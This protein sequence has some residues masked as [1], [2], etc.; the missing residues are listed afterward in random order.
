[1][2]KKADGGLTAIIII[3]I[4]VLAIGWLVNEGYKEC[5]SDSDCSD[6][7]YCGSDFSCHQHKVIKESAAPININTAAWV[8]G[9]SLII[10]AI[11][12]KWDTIFKKKKKKKKEEDEYIELSHSKN[13]EDK[14]QY[15]D[16]LEDKS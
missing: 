14:G 3:I 4:I 6:T 8:I 10:A 7:E 1:M 5:R 11:I 12:M 16:F 15:E 2:N 9:I 13:A